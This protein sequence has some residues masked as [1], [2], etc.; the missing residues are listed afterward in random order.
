MEVE[1]AILEGLPESSNKLAAED[2]TE[3]MDGKK[4]PIRVILPSGCARRTDRRRE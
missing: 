1:L 3:H 2:A 4:E